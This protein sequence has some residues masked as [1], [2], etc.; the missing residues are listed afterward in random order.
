MLMHST[1][2]CH[3]Q[4]NKQG[5]EKFMRL[6]KN[7]RCPVNVLTTERI[8]K[9]VS[10]VQGFI[11]MYHHLEQQRQQAAVAPV[12]EDP[13]SLPPLVLCC[14]DWSSW[15]QTGTPRLWNWKVGEWFQASWVF[16]WLWLR[17]CPFRV[18]QECKGWIIVMTSN[19][20]NCDDE[21]WLW[22]CRDCRIVLQ[23]FTLGFCWSISSLYDGWRWNLPYSTFS[24]DDRR[25]GK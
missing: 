15:Q 24:D 3:Y 9:F 18:E 7:C 13:N 12:I 8:E 10:L 23:N 14:T 1:N 11:C 19:D 5:C 21:Q 17:I 22:A 25:M 2:V 20:C 16:S 4:G 6:V